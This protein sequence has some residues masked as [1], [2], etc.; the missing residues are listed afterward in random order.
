[1]SKI[2][3]RLGW[4]ALVV[5]LLSGCRLFKK[6][7]PVQAKPPPRKVSVTLRLKALPNLNPNDR[8]EPTPVDVRIYQLK[9]RPTFTEAAFEELWTK[10]KDVLGPA[11]VGAP[12]V[13]TLQPAGEDAAP[14]AHDLKLDID[15][16]FL[17]IMA[18]FSAERKEGLEE[19]KLCVSIDEADMK[20]FEFSKHKIEITKLKER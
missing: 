6:E 11:M 12:V 17:G 18:L 2:V 10:D 4:F 5:V 16:K 13:V 9:D 14:L 20:T 3:A 7:E 19:R 1:M 8:G 15:T